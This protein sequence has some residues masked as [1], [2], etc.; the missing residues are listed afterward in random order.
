M[1]T[2]GR[3]TILITFYNKL[4]YSV[5]MGQGV[6]SVKL[7]LSEELDTGAHFLLLKKLEREDDWSVRQSVG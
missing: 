5:D 6:H 4:G 1:E 2:S 7:D 3:L